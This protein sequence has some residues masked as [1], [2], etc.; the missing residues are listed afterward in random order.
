MNKSLR[1]RNVARFHFRYRWLTPLLWI[2]SLVAQNTP[3]SLAISPAIATMRVGES[4]RFR[5]V[6]QQ[7][8]APGNIYWTTSDP[9]AL[10]SEEADGELVVTAM[11][12]GNFRIT[13]RSG[14]RAAE[15]KIKVVEGNSLPP[16][17]IIWSSAQPAGCKPRQ[18][19]PAVPTANGPALFGVS[20]CEDG[21]Y[22]EALTADGVR[23]W[24]RRIGDA[25]AALADLGQE[26]P[27]TPNRL[28]FN[29][30]SVCDA[31]T[32]GTEQDKVKEILKSRNLTF[33]EDMHQK[34]TWIVEEPSTQC[35]F[36]FDQKSVL[37]RK[38]KTLVAQ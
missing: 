8:R 37:T 36:W 6:D 5:A 27:M 3:Y 21:T 18:I 2:S 13:V 12:P 25:H 16:G 11:Q 35:R 22:V 28:D 14:D 31:V 32:I 4:R 26:K 23:L 15:A 38:R 33:T 30:S 9:A 7:G 19:I 24:R 29:S 17:S 1:G 10:V 20:D 34:Q